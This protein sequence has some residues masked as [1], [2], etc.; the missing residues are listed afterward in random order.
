MD[1]L[2]ALANEVRA[3]LKKRDSLTD[4]DV[5]LLKEVASEMEMLLEKH[6]SGRRPTFDQISSVVIKIAHIIFD[7]I[8]L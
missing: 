7:N 5:R 4:A 1:K 3:M 6:V 2:E 8:D